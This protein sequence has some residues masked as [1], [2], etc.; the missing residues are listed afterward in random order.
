MKLYDYQLAPNPRRVRIFLAEK[1]ITVPT[2]Q[3]DL[4]AGEQFTPEFR[5]ITPEC[6]VPV[7]EFDD[8]RRIAEVIAICLYF[9]LAHPAGADGVGYKTGRSS[10]I[11]ITASSG[12][13]SGYH[14]TFR[15]SAPRLK[16]RLCRA[17]PRYE[18]ISALAGAASRTARFF[19]CWTAWRARFRRHDRFAIRCSS[20][21]SRWMA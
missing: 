17:G 9:E 7:L 1:G 20:A 21:S 14:N 3:V 11:G 5:S 16:G 4:R 8:G 18:Q 6:T 12:K 15:N 2:V 10:P 13:A 19:G